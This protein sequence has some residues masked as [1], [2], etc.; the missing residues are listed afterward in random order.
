MPML[1]HFDPRLI[2]DVESA[3]QAMVHL[4]NL[5]EE[6]QQE[7]LSQ[8]AEIQALRDEIN[9]L[10]GEDGKPDIKANKKQKEDHSSEKE[11]K[12]SSRKRRKRKK[13][14]EVKIDHEEILRIDKSQLPSD[15]KF[16]GYEEVIVQDLRIETANTRFRKEKYYS[17]S[18]RKTYLAELPKGYKGQFGPTIRALVP[19]LYYAG[20]M[21]EPKIIELLEQMG[22]NISKGKVSTLLSKETALWQAEADAILLSGLSSSNWQHIDDTSTRVNGVNNYCHILCNPF[23]TSY[24]TRPKKNRLNVITV[25][26][27]S[28]KTVCLFNQQT[29]KWL[30]K[31]NT[32]D[33]VQKEIANWS[34]R[35]LI[36][37]DEVENWLLDVKGLNLQQKA[38]IY[39]AG[40]LTAY[41][42]QEKYP[43][44]PI[45]VSDNAPQFHHLTEKQSLC[46]VHEGRHYKKLLP[47]VDYHRKI[48]DEILKEFW[49]YYHKLRAY[50]TDPSPEKATALRL[51]F[52]MIFSQKTDY[53]QLNQRLSK[54]LAHQEKLLLVL[55]YPE[56]PL[57]NNSAE[58]G[59]RQ[60]V[61][62]RDVSFGPRTEEGKIAWDSLMT[63]AETAKKLKVSFY[64]Y[65]LD[66]ISQKNAMPS[67][68]ELIRLRTPI[69][70][71]F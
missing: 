62:K 18:T 22:V 36:A 21:S 40:A 39:E 24:A 10:K 33:W 4:L 37:L 63:V 14:S 55:D 57:H 47:Q 56:V 51:E 42:S 2:Q 52:E 69:T 30:E 50:K 58:L 9:R 64:Q 11:R 27:N 19:S 70:P 26:Q 46:W 13:H 66:R 41:Y 31:F 61:R 49:E 65:V 7:N 45:L 3:R 67:L 43:V 68:A 34:S 25:L 23:Y 15:A 35:K 1:K 6:L 59:G 32:P 71:I 17:A 48:L 29:E 28:E 60:R 20:G 16:K 12:G 5:V 54:T 44:I 53:E 38:R 8:R